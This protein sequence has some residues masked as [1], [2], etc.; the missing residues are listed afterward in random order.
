M[1]RAMLTRPLWPLKNSQSASPA[2]LAM[3]Y[4]C[5]YS[6]SLHAQGFTYIGGIFYRVPSASLHAQGY[7]PSADTE[8]IFI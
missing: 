5:E 3:P 4:P 8:G 7:T 1:R 6:P 2:A